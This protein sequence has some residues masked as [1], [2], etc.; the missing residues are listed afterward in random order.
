M[1]MRWKNVPPILLILIPYL[2]LF[3][4]VLSSV[5]S[6]IMSILPPTVAGMYIPVLLFGALPATLVL[7]L[8]CVY[9]GKWDPDATARWNLRIKLFLIPVYVF[10]FVFAI[11]VP[12]AIPF[13]FLVDV[14]MLL[15]SSCYGFQALLRTRKEERMEK[16]IFLVLF[17]CHFCFVADVVAAFVLRRKLNSIPIA[18]NL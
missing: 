7:N 4:I 2:I 15:T 13:L 12:L 8:L 6:A 5:F 14:V 3:P 1:T 16:G 18:Q 11:A 10:I 9:F 17:L